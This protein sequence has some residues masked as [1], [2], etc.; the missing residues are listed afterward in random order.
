MLYKASRKG[1]VKIVGRWWHVGEAVIS[2]FQHLSK[3]S[4]C[5][6]HFLG[7]VDM[8][9]VDVETCLEVAEAVSSRGGRFLEAPLCGSKEAAKRGC[10]TVLAAGDKSLYDDCQSCFNGI[11][12]KAFYLG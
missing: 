3:F 7:Y 4:D 5:F 12:K 11:S 1:K 9:T 8:S 2:P 6:S 10:L